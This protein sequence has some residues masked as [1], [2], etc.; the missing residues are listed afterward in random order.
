M[1][2]Y[3]FAVTVVQFQLAVVMSFVASHYANYALV[4]S[5]KHCQKHLPW[6]GDGKTL[7]ECRT[8]VLADWHCNLG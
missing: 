4:A 6:K 5:G 3:Q 1:F 7:D 2:R 8:A